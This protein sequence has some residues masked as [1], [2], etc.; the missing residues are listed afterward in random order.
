MK[1]SDDGRWFL[2]GERQ[3]P[4]VKVGI[5]DNPIE[6]DRPPFRTRLCHIKG[7]GWTLSI[8]WGDCTY[9]DNYDARFA[10]LPS[11]WDEDD[12]TLPPFTEDPE[13]VEVMVLDGPYCDSEPRSFQS[14][15]DVLNLIDELE[16]R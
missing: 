4:V 14:A 6:A 13:H 1:L 15:D 3:I 16:G 10:G 12:E 7:E 8:I 9:S 5:K 11:F 2:V